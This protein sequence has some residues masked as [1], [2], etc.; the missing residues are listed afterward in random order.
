MAIRNI[1]SGEYISY[2]EQ[3]KHAEEYKIKNIPK[4]DFEK[5]L[6]LKEIIKEIQGKTPT[7]LRN[8]RDRGVRIEV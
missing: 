5:G 2:D 1:I 6:S 8:E 7:K 3:S 4:R